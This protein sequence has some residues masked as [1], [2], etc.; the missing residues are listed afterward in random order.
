MQAA[1]SR[2]PG[3]CPGTHRRV[4][5]RVASV[6][7]GSPMARWTTVMEAFADRDTWGVRELATHTG[8]P[9]S[10]VHR[11]LHEM[12]RL[13]LLAEA[14][15]PGRFR[16]GPSLARLS[17]L[18]AER[19]DVRAIARPIMEVA[20]AELDETLVLAL[21]SSAR[22]QFWAVDAVEIDPAY[23]LHLGSAA[24]VERAA[25]RIKRQGHPRLPAGRRAG[26]HPGRAARPAPRPQADAHR[27][28]PRGTG[29]GP[30]PRPCH[31]PRRAVPGS[32]GCLGPHPRR[33]G[34]RHR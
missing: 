20:A 1:I 33:H 5:R 2:Q 8:L 27:H 26:R 16:I 30:R 17:V 25:H 19:L 31:Q 10:A 7:P 3:V 28:H 12:A 29:C 6:T 21:Y 13:E 14:G 32:G 23:P 22:R 9:R 34:A 24:A 11:M 4:A 15:A 18:L